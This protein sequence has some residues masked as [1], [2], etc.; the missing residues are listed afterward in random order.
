MASDIVLVSLLSR[1]VDVTPVRPTKFYS[2][3]VL[4]IP[5]FTFPRF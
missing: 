4:L 1:S 3:I 5:I 2:A